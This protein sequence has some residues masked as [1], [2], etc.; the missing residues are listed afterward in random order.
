[1]SAYATRNEILKT[2][3]F[4]NY[5]AYL[6]SELWQ[7]IRRFVMNNS[8]A[9]CKRC[10]SKAHSIHHM[11]YERD[12]LE[13]R[14]TTPLVPVCRSCHNY[15]EVDHKGRKVCLRQANFIIKNPAAFNVGKTRRVHE[16]CRLCGEECGGRKTCLECRRKNRRPRVCREPLTR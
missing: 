4:E 12:V 8:R 16:K 15:A 1:M 13:G 9:I 6:R 10:G 7:S 3:G 5:E 11:S 2:M 14:D